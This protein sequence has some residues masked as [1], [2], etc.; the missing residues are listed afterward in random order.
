VSSSCSWPSSF[1]VQA[2][3]RRRGVKVSWSLTGELGYGAPATLAIGEDEG[4]ELLVLLR[5][6]RPLLQPNLVAARLPPHC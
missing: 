2:T 4:D 5:R 3:L 6:P 1:G